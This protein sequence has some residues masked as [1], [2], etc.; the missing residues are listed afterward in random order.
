VQRSP[1]IV[2]IGL[3]LH[4]RGGVASV[5]ATFAGAGFF[6]RKEVVYHCSCGDGSKFDKLFSI[7]KQW[8]KFLGLLTA[9]Q[10]DLAHIHFS[11]DS[12]FWRKVPYILLAK[13]FRLKLL[14]NV[15]P[16]HFYDYFAKASPPIQRLMKA[17]LGCADCLG[18]ANANLIAAFRP[19]FPHLRLVHLRNPVDLTRYYPPTLPQRRPQALYLG[20]ILPIK[21]V[22]DIVKAVELL[23]AKQRELCFIFCGDYETDKLRNQ[24]QDLRLNSVVQVRDW[25]SYETKLELLQQSSMLLLPSYSEGF[26]MVVLEAMACGLPVISTPVG[27]LA[28]VLR[29]GENALLV[30]PGNPEMLAEKIEQL[31]IDAALRDKLV[32][33]GDELVRRH[34]VRLVMKDLESLYHELVSAD[35][36][37]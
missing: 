6:D 10:P 1:K 7:V 23:K 15:H 18:F 5:L 2:V 27:G 11:A 33:H 3:S 34:D 19:Y 35:A 22:Y 8:V 30:E 31:L 32:A 28:G 21:G 29:D 26:P 9:K 36:E 4:R 13:L 14:L 37:H 12:S 16:T 20:A 25:I 17:V 24:V